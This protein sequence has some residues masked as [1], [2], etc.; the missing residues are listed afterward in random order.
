MITNLHIHTEYSFQESL[1]R[2][3]DLVP[4]AKR[5]GYSCLAITDT[6]GM[7][8]VVK[9]Y[10]LCLEWEIKPVIGALIRFTNTCLILLAKS[11][12]GYSQMNA[13]L[14]E[15]NKG[16]APPALLSYI[17]QTVRDCFILSPCP[18]ILKALNPGCA[19]NL[20]LEL[21]LWSNSQEKN[22]LMEAAKRTGFPVVPTWPSF[23]FFRDDFETLAL[24]TA[25]KHNTD[26]PSARVLCEKK[27]HGFF[28][29]RDELQ[30]LIRNRPEW[31]KNIER[32]TEECGVR[33]EF[34]RT[35][36]PGIGTGRRRDPCRAL[37]GLCMR[38]LNALEAREQKPAAEYTAR[39]R[40]ELRVIRFLKLEPYFLIVHR[41]AQ[42]ARS[43]KISF[44]GRGSAANSLVCYLLGITHVDPVRHNL[45]FERFLHEKRDG[46]PDIDLDFP[47]NRRDRVLQFVYGR[48]NAALISEHVRFSVR[49]CLRET[50]KAFG[51]GEKEIGRVTDRIP[52]FFSAEGLTRLHETLPGLKGADLCGKLWQTILSCAEK[53]M[54]L[55]RNISIHPG[56]MVIAQNP[57]S[58]FT[59]LEKAPRGFFVTQL[60]MRDAE[61]MGLLK[62]DLLGQRA[63]AVMDSAFA[64]LP[65][66]AEKREEFF[67][68]DPRT[69]G[70]IRSG[71]SIGCFYIESPAMRQL[72]KKL[73]VES[74][75]ELTAASSIIRPG[76]AESG[77]MQKYIRFH[78][79]PSSVTYVHP[80]LKDLLYGTH[81][82]MIYQEDVLRVAAACA[83]FP[84]EDADILRKSMSGKSRSV[85]GIQGLKERF[86][87]GCQERG[88][89]AAT[90]QQLWDQV[91]SFA[92]YAFCK[93]HSASYARISFVVAYL[94]A[95]HPAE[96]LSAVISNRGGFYAAFVYV[97]EARRLGL[98]VLPPDLNRAGRD[99]TPFSKAIMPG[100]SFV[101]EIPSSTMETIIRE[102]E[103]APFADP[104]DFVLRSGVSEKEF[105][106]LA[107]AGCL[108]W[109]GLARK[110]LFFLSGHVKSMRKNRASLPLFPRIP[111]AV[112][113]TEFS[114]KK[115]VLDEI[116]ALGFA[117][118]GNPML[119]ADEPDGRVISS[120]QMAAHR[121]R[122][123]FMKGIRICSKQVR[124]RKRPDPMKFISFMDQYGFF[125]AFLPPRNYA[126]LAGAS[127]G[128]PLCLLYGKITEDYNAYTLN[129]EEI[130]ALDA[131]LSIDEETR[132]E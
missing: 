124:G 10:R 71:E 115:R 56:G 58:L 82:I 14:T 128:P 38:R 47:S 23:F 51:L 65:G 4:L 46:F 25:V 39:L 7:Y 80:D 91:E 70:L 31:V 95:H 30:A 94:K 44:T 2:V 21:P 121:N 118:S 129:L 105:L 13:V 5:Y 34:N 49:S 1:M 8:G 57:L 64:L 55:P 54:G 84:P 89:A 85:Q 88:Y 59:A 79:D 12:A 48:F 114:V 120:K 9:F 37:A 109:T 28:I 119:L 43:E 81:G 127:L 17:R 104:V 76:V 11:I 69:I 66:L 53:L 35:E 62:I 110:Q 108:D 90:A 116:E 107:K 125:E 41:I 29:A 27:R 103:K 72:L 117:V 24:L 40:K 68:R 132:E 83:G 33:F 36:L 131:G 92:G 16:T 75:E 3:K 74:F 60:D 32:I 98:A 22:S 123:V 113:A 101:R 130:T 112:G 63:L 122:H 42:Y 52:Y 97:E 61:K 78:N 102:R 26:L 15:K 93:A 6:N 86:L 99:F 96:F 87:S 126:R 19:G 45:L 18:G 50:A 67:F 20:F 100:L 106:L 73:K 77:M 111:R